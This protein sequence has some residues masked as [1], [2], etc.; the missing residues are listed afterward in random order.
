M[1]VE[2]AHLHLTLFKA[3]VQVSDVETKALE[4]CWVFLDNIT[5]ANWEFLEELFGL[6]EL[7]VGHRLD[8]HL[9]HLHF[10]STF[11]NFKL[12]NLDVFGQENEFL[13]ERI[14]VVLHN[15]QFQ[16]ESCVDVS[17][18][19]PHIGKS[20][21]INLRIDV[22]L[23]LPVTVFVHVNTCHFGSRKTIQEQRV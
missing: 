7:D 9:F 13:V 20:F 14:G 2:G 1:L 11:Q 19:V 6:L 22:D 21:N 5:N 15:L 16:N 4:F 10:F 3:D 12:G 17:D 8:H 23:E 18:W